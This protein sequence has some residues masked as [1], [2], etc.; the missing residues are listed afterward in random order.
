[1][2]LG[3]QEQSAVGTWKFEKYIQQRPEGT[4]R[5]RGYECMHHALCVVFLR[6]QYGV[7]L[8]VGPHFVAVCLAGGQRFDD[9]SN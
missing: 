7:P 4:L 2:L 9:R 6:D 3:P 5:T 8:G 1:V